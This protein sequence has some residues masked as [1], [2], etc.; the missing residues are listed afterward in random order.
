MNE[1]YLQAIC[2]GTSVKHDPVSALCFVLAYHCIFWTFPKEHNCVHCNLYSQ[3][4]TIDKNATMLCIF[5]YDICTFSHRD[6]HVKSSERSSTQCAF[7]LHSSQIKYILGTKMSFKKKI[8][9]HRLEE[10]EERIYKDIKQKNEKG[11]NGTGRGW[12]K[13]SRKAGILIALHKEH[14][15]NPLASLL[16]Y[17][18]GGNGSN[19]ASGWPSKV[20]RLYPPYV[21][22]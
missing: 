1:W 11:L 22:Q 5:G 16:T 2:S 21:L 14:S 8:A 20:L 19:L 17:P 6:L 10:G 18:Q 3:L 15:W 13:C 4:G 7:F 12:F 9:G